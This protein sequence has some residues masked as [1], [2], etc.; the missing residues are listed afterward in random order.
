MDWISHII[1]GITV[2]RLA[3]M[4]RPQEWEKYRTVI[5]LIAIT[6]SLFPDLDILGTHRSEL[7]APLVLT[8]LAGVICLAYPLSFRP[9]LAGFWSHSLLDIFLFDNSKDT[10]RQIIDIAIT[11]DTAAS[12]VNEVVVTGV[13]ANGIMLL[14][15][16]SRKMY[17]I[18]LTE[19]T[20]AI[21]AMLVLCTAVITWYLTR[22]NMGNYR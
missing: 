1:F 12:E 8:I 13:A 4:N 6:A 17:S 20:Y 16:I 11:N 14:Y 5:I 9:M 19:T 21:V 18:V 10:I 15:P 3:F 2:T 22:N 7:H